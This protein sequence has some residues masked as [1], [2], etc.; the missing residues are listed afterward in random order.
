MGTSSRYDVPR[1]QQRNVSDTVADK[2]NAV[3]HYFQPNVVEVEAEPSP[4]LC[5]RF[6]LPDSPPNE[7]DTGELR[8]PLPETIEGLRTRLQYHADKLQMTARNVRAVNT[9]IRDHHQHASDIRWKHGMSPGPQMPLS[10]FP[11]SL[12]IGFS[13]CIKLWS[14][15]D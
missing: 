9:W 2:V 15:E 3:K 1:R 10:Y 7:K 8:D 11:A 12:M 4:A 6:Q 5:R 13:Q 14:I